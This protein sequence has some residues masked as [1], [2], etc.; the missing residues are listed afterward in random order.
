MFR[1]AGWLALLA[2]AGCAAV[3]PVPVNSATLAQLAYAQN[4][5]VRTVSDALD[6]KLDLL[7]AARPGRWSVPTAGRIAPERQEHAAGLV[8]AGEPISRNL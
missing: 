5:V 6:Q 8:S 2:V 1:P 4:G 7:L 3:R